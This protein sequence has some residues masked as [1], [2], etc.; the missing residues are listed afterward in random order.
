MKVESNLLLPLIAVAL[1]GLALSWLVLFGGPPAPVPTATA[2]QLTSGEAPQW[3]SPRA[4]MPQSFGHVVR[5]PETG[6]FV[7]VRDV[8][9]LPKFDSR[10]SASAD[11]DPALALGPSFTL[12]APYGII[13]AMTFSSGP[14]A[15]MLA[16]VRGP[17]RESICFNSSQRL[18]ACGLAARAALNNT[19]KKQTVRC[20]TRQVLNA[21]RVIASC[22]TPEGDL[23]V[24]L[25]RQGWV[26][27]DRSSRADLIEAARLAEEGQLG[28]WNGGWRIR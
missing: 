22:T 9:Q 8:R 11:L 17:D 26:R 14:W 20:E 16:D 15:I 7:P 21:E 1:A 18:F 3:L 6:R 27:P 10:V 5:Q 28:L 2:P 12:N 25:A 23:A 24:L 19:L 4:D 13:D